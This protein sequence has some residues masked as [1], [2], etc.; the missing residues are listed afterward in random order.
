MTQIDQI[1]NY[2]AKEIQE[3]PHKEGLQ[4]TNVVNALVRIVLKELEDFIN[5]LPSSNPNED[6]ADAARN[7]L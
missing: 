6:S 4:E 3:F 1:K 7:I 2:I 5:S